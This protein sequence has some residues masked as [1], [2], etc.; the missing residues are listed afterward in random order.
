[1]ICAKGGIIRAPEDDG[2]CVETLQATM[3]ATNPA[4]ILIFWRTAG[5][6][7]WFG[8]D[9]AFDAE[10]LAR[11]GETQRAA[12]RGD[13]E[14]WA[15]TDDGALALVIVLDQFPRNLFRGTPQAFATDAYARRIAVAAIGRGAD[16]R[17]DPL[18]R[19]FFYLPLMHSETLADQQRGVALY[20]VLGDAEQLKYAIDH[21]DIIARFGRFPHRN[22]I[23]GRSTT[24]EEQAYLDGGGFKG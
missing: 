21:R 11:F 20:E 8:K 14:N 15:A 13:L 24:P 1:M 7:T 12:A 9:D 5:F 19:P 18:L 22:V 10:I 4:T 2:K 17:A 23:L 6:E 16:M 3:S